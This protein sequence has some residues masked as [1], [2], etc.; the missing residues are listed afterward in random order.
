MGIYDFTDAHCIQLHPSLQS[1]GRW[2]ALHWS[3]Q[4]LMFK[5]QGLLIGLP[6]F[7]SIRNS[8]FSRLPAPLLRELPATMVP[9]VLPEVVLGLYVI[10]GDNL[11]P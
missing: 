4:D 11:A 2:E 5:H 10:R 8:N 7:E 9:L 6:L 1:I 3:P